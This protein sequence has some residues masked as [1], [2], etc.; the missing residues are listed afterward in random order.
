M[1]EKTIAEKLL[2]K[3]Y[4]RVL[5]INKSEGYLTKIGALPSGV[6]VLNNLEENIDLIQL[7]VTLKKQLEAQ[8][9][10][11]KMFSLQRDCSG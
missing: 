5:F 7:F 10:E 1:S 4:Y 11:L 3:E 9:A 2:R 8:L 6:T